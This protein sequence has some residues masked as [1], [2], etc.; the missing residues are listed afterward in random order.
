L[1]E[2]RFFQYTSQTIYWK[3]QVFAHVKIVSKMTY[4]AVTSIGL[5]RMCACQ[6]PILQC[7]HTAHSSL[8]KMFTLVELHLL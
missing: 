8:A 5:F 3:C 7:A 4:N 2:V 1:A 6:H